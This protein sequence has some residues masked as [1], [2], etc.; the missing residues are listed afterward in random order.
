MAMRPIP[1]IE[2]L[3]RDAKRLRAAFD[4]GALAAR[5]RVEA[6]VTASHTELKHADFLHVI[7]KETG[8]DSWPR[9]V[10]AAETVGLDRAARQQRLGTALFHGQAFVIEQLLS[11]TLD[12]AQQDFG[13]A[14]ALYDLG[15][16]RRML[17]ESPERATRPC[18]VRRPIL[19]LAFSRYIHMRPELEPDMLALADLLLAHGADVN[20]SMPVAPDNDHPLSALYGAIGHGNNMALGAWLLEHGADPNDGESLYH[21]TELGHH[22]GLRLLLQHGADPKGTNALLRAMDFHDHTAVEMLLAHGARADDFDGSPVGGET[23]WV[24]PALHQAARRGS[25]AR[26]VELLLDAGADGTR[27]YQGASVFGYARVFGNHALSQALEARGLASDLSPEEQLLARA[28]DRY[29]TPGR[30]ID[31][32]RLPETYRTILQMLVPLPERIGQIKR[33]VALGM[34]YD[35]PD[36][37]GLT[38]VQIAG[39]EGLPE[40]MGYFLQLKPDLGHVNGYGGTL[41]STILHGSENAPEAAKRDH[42]AC[43][44]M[45]LEEGV[46]LPRHAITAAGREETRDFLQDWADRYPGQVV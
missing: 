4:T 1:P 32:A 22:T 30:F 38:P 3:K 17:D 7:A 41:L 11:E 10:W 16:V 9:L 13:L 19:H 45:A 44:R 36:S 34:E 28:A 40:V 35:R 12:L 37:T 39:W 33:L 14:C 43:L 5:Q 18:G 31:P 20:D 2:Q 21:A 42:I 26:M 46:A 6:Y 15:T 25:D 23:P 24:V 27:F 8:F 29:D